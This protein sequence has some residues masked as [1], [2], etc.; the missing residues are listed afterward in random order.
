[1]I[2]LTNP[3][4]KSIKKIVNKSFDPISKKVDELTIK[5]SCISSEIKQEIINSNLSDDI[6]QLFLSIRTC[7]SKI[8]I[9][10][11]IRILYTELTQ[12]TFAS[13]PIIYKVKEK[14]SE[15]LGIT[16]DEFNKYLF[17]C[18]SKGWITLIEG[19]PFSGKETDWYDIAGRRFYYFEFIPNHKF[20]PDFYSQY[21][22]NGK[23]I[24]F[25]FETELG[26]EY[27]E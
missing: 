7:S 14:L 19:S 15:K 9:T 23:R 24:P 21:G 6:K 17:E 2:P 12:M 4:E 5:C 1:M 20:K 22:M 27:H 13:R 11:F 26:I 25:M 3:D 8:E 10:N 18:V 16:D